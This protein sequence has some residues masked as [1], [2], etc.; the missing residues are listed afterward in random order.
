MLS[1][2]IRSEGN[3]LSGE[4]ASSQ[5]GVSRAAVNAAVQGLRAEGYAI[6]SVTNRGYRLLHA[7]DTLSTG[8]LLA[9][10]GSSRLER[11]LC[12]ETVDSTNKYLLELSEKGAADGQVVL[13][14]M[15]TAGRGRIGKQFA[16]PGGQG[17]YLSYLIHPRKDRGESAFVRDWVTVT[18]RTAVAV[19]NAIEDVCHVTPKIK[20]V[21]DL[22]LNERKICGI[23]TQTD[24]EAESGAIRSLVIGIGV[25]VHERTEDFPEELRS[26]A[27]SIDQET[28]GSFSRPVLAAAIIKRLD[29]MRREL[30]EN[31]AY[32]LKKYREH[33]MVPGREI[34]LTGS[35]GEETV[36]ALRISDTFGLVV[37]KADGTETELTGGEILRML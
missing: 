37:Q 29:E 33:C 32:Y 12:L 13:A 36:K 16:S 5:I 8:A 9:E 19:L 3:Y 26:I 4:E 10:L 14:D 25:N 2:L 15:Q 6:D 35:A 21:N 7:P 17:I 22:F 24:L 28:G 20:W 30:P 31:T 27:T 23:L 11:V 1:L 34:V 18:G